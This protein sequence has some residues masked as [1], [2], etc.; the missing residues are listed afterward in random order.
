MANYES[1]AKQK[2]GDTDAYKEYV[3]RTTD[4]TSEKWKQANNGLNN[5]LAKFAEHMQGG[6]T[7]NS[8]EVQALVKELQNH[9]T[10]NYYT[11]TNQILLGLGKM[12]VADE[13]FKTS[14]DKHGNGTAEYVCKAIEI[15]C[16]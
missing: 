2:W 9:I 7:S 4:Y 1:E 6:Y 8:T 10:N 16:S 15:Y 14:I 12:Y 3:N 5:V 13:R 11:C